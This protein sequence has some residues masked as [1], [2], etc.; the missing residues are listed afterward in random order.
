MDVLLLAKLIVSQNQLGKEAGQKECAPIPENGPVLL[1]S[2]G[3]DLA[4]GASSDGRLEHDSAWLVNREPLVAQHNIEVCT[5]PE[6]VLERL[7]AWVLN[8]NHSDQLKIFLGQLFAQFL[9]EKLEVNP[10]DW[11]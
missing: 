11:P 7:L 1:R 10:G 6:V 9:L 5:P 8:V 2:S 3:H 4:L